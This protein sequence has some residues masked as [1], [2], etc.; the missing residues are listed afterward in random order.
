MS[1]IAFKSL[2]EILPCCA[3]EGS[4]ATHLAVSKAIEHVTQAGAVS[5]SE[6]RLILATC[7]RI[8]DSLALLDRRLLLAGQWQFV[9]F[10]AQLVARSIL[11]ALCDEDQDFF[12]RGHWEQG[13]HRPEELVEAQR[14]LLHGLEAGRVS[15]HRRSAAQP[16][17]FVYVAWGL[18]RLDGKFLL[19]HR[20]DKTRRHAGNFVL[21]GGRFNFSD[22]PAE[23]QVPQA[24]PLI[25]R[26]ESSEA[27]SCLER[28]LIREI[29]EEA[30]LR[31]H[32]HYEFKHWRRLRP[33]RDVEGT[34]NN[35]AY[36]E[37]LIQ[38]FEVTLTALGLLVLLEKLSEYPEQF[39]WF[40][41]RDLAR[42]IRSDGK[43]AYLEALHADLGDDMCP[44]LDEV[45]EAFLDRPNFQGETDAIDFPMAASSQMVRGRT[46]KERPVPVEFSGDERAILFGLAWHAKRLPFSSMGHVVLLPSGWVKVLDENQRAAI[47][48]LAEKLRGA[49]CDLIECRDDQFFR[50]SAVAGLLFFDE[51][52]FRYDVGTDDDDKERDCWFRIFL[53]VMDTP[54]GRTAGVDHTFQVTRN[55]LRIIKS[56]EARLDPEHNSRIKSGD[57]SRMIRDQ[58][59][60]Q[61]RSFG[62]R[63]FLRLSGKEYAIAIARKS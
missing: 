36:T 41:P 3:E 21:P 16:I 43:A 12:E 48:L 34:R 24:L 19:H 51:S 13:S 26:A 27:L 29:S 28:T 18:I 50:I 37:Y 31:L 20:E 58:V 7:Q 14:T 22:L 35:H 8:F 17:R 57:I 30:G 44:A 42:R 54:I 62:L 53:F 47:S 25:Q 6:A 55:T 60:A 52:G 15:S 39:A 10:P 45:P 63:K 4:L 40:S 59:D 46:G 32:D 9:S 2:A 11:S 49:E 33:Y 38:I 23:L 56:I 61:T 1:T 5:P